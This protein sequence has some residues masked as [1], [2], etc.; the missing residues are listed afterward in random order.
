MK[1]LSMISKLVPQKYS[2]NRYYTGILRCAWQKACNRDGMLHTIDCKE[3]Y[4]LQR[5]YFDLS[6]YGT[7]IKQHLGAA[8]E[9]IPTLD[10]FRFGFVDADKEQLPQLPGN[11]CFQHWNRGAVLL[12]DNVL[13]SGKIVEPLVEGDLDTVALLEYNKLLNTDPRLETVLPP[14]R[15][16]LTITRVK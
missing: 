5:K 12:S 14:I 16:G 13:W 9:I 10:R 1:V 11:Y 3:L 6:G 8:L 2:G 7:Q 4:D 15:D